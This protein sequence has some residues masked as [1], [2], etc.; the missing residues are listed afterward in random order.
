MS[1]STPVLLL[2]LVTRS[3]RMYITRPRFPGCRK[4]SLSFGTFPLALISHWPTLS[5]LFSVITL[6]DGHYSNRPFNA[7]FLLDF[8]IVRS[9]HFSRQ[10]RA[11]DST[12]KPQ[13]PFDDSDFI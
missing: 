11:T 7:N 13:L 2:L 10:L 8:G 1:H 3:L 4:R 12:R 5:P 6:E 9:D